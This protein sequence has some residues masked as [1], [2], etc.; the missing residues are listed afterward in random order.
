MKWFYPIALLV[1]AGLTSTPI[2]LL[3]MLPQYQDRNAYEGKI[4]RY[5][6][7]GSAVRSIDPAT[8]GDTTSSNFQG[9]V[10]EGLYTYHFL[11][12]PAHSSVIPQLAAKMPTVSEDQ[13]TYTIP[14]KQGVLYHRNPCFGLDANGDPAT[15]EMVADD[16]VLAFKR[17]A[18]YHINTGLSWAF[19]TRI[20]GLKDYRKKTQKYKIGDF[21]RYDLPVEGVK[22]LDDHTLRITLAEPFP[23]F[24]YVLAMHAY[25]PIPREAVDYWLA[26][27][28]DGDGGRRSIPVEKRRTEFREPKQSVGTG[29]Y[30]IFDWQRKARFALM[31]NPDYRPVFYP[32]EGEPG[33]RQAGLLDDA[34]QRVPFIDVLHYDFVAETSS[35]WKLFLTRQRDSSGISKDVFETVI[36]PRRELE[37]R[38]K[39][40]GIRLHKYSQP[41]VYWIVF[42]MEDPVIGA[43]KSL[44]QALSLSFD[45][46]TYLRVLFNDRGRP[47]VNI[48]P[49]TFQGWA[50]AGPSPYATFDLDRAKAKLEQ[51]KKE[52][53][54]AGQLVDG[55]IPPLELDF[56]AT[57]GE[58][59]RRGDFFRQQFAQVGIKL[60]PVYQDWPKLQEKVHNKQ[61]QM[62][63]MGWHA[64]YPDAENFLQ[65]YY[66]PNIEKGTNNSNYSSPAYDRLFE[67]VRVMPDSPE[68]TALYAGMVNIISE[69][70]PV[71]LL[72]EPVSYVL[73]YDW[74]KNVK[75]HPIGYGYTKYRRIDVDR[76]RELG[77]KE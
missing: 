47:A 75:P 19:A 67:K 16:F 49:S 7:Y 56:G 20:K 45:V 51:A 13:L 21:S 17:I 58:M 36:N 14:L 63:T 46:K 66:S 37:D 40:K 70:C 8:C 62:Y 48:L 1:V 32:T 29:P 59:V 65:L 64:D 77:G 68:R 18:D 39:R 25:A 2:W 31:R 3:G 28:D 41:A 11:K 22:A 12:R 44:R 6:L 27:E 9:N 76:R 26:S 43:S 55:D 15:R 34:G 60:K 73:V 23:Q 52:L 4:V 10:Y 54:A 38:W 69:D 30:Y 53:A 5:D 61:T 33:D 71:L 42:N 35:A 74:V 24:K 50:E 57:G 72:T